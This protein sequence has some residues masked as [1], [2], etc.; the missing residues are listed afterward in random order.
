MDRPVR[1]AVISDT[2]VGIRAA[3]DSLETFVERANTEEYDLI[4]HTGDITEIGSEEELSE[5]STLV[6]GLRMPLFVV[7][8]N[9]DLRWSPGGWTGVESRLGPRYRRLDLGPVTVLALDSSTFGEPY[10]ALDRGQLDWIR[11]ELNTIQEPVILAIHHMPFDPGR[12][13]LA[14]E[15]E[16][17]ELLTQSKKVHL[18]LCGHGHGYRI[19]RRNGI[20]IVMTGA[21][22]QNGF[23]EI[24][25]DRKGIDVLRVSLEKDVSSRDLRV[26]FNRKLPA[27]PEITRCLESSSGKIEISIRGAEEP[28]LRT[29]LDHREVK[30]RVST[31]DDG[32][33][34]TL[35]TQ[36][37]PPGWHDILCLFGKD[38]ADLLAVRSVLLS[39]RPGISSVAIPSG[40]IGGAAGL[41]GQAFVGSL[42][43]KVRAI[44][45]RE[46][47]VI[48]AHPIGGR[49]L[50]RPEIAGEA[51]IAGTELGNLAALDRRGQILW[52]RDLGSAVTGA[53]RFNSERNL[54][55]VPTGSGALL[56][57]DSQD[58]ATRWQF[59]S[60]GPIHVRPEI[61]DGFAFFGSWDRH[62][63]AVDLASGK[64]R[65]SYKTDESFYFS[66]ST[67]RP[68]AREGIVIFP[69]PRRK[70][71]SECVLALDG[72]S[73]RKLWG[74]SAS[75]AYANPLLV[76]T[77]GLLTEPN[78]AIYALSLESGERRWSVK[79]PG[80]FWRSSPVLSGGNTYLFTVEGTLYQVDPEN[81]NPRAILRLPRSTFFAS[82]EVAGSQL[83]LPTYDGHLWI[84]PLRGWY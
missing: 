70:V 23:R 56:A 75:S 10:G 40:S 2:H 50:V 63:Y 36:S 30:A 80:S 64:G 19:W 65:W 49:I 5:F 4:L 57:V 83:V 67:A 78:G 79:I 25:I 68:A 76:K 37:L 32:L 42:D 77:V 22:F 39:G 81:G 16:L 45:P 58:G 35:E 14:G 71:G 11:D 27:L 15:G 48:W 8:G 12:R 31:S 69:F 38:P 43:G 7:P 52:K 47:K 82:P 17:E 28:A 3:R 84:L 55:L 53:C 29:I 46:R 61:Q 54:C 62:F 9:H 66:P 24:R 18:F 51:I 60:Q 20:P 21:L 26:D 72:K 59:E 6:R 33:V 41:S 44:D 34:L 73:G 13:Y 74:H 1:M